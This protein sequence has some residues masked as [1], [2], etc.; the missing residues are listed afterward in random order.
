MYVLTDYHD[1]DD[2]YGDDELISKCH[3]FCLFLLSIV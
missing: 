1:D 3:F 2:D